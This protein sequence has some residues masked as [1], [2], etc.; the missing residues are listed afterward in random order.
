M[1]IFASMRIIS[2]NLLNNSINWKKATHL[3]TSHP[4]SN[5]GQRSV[6][7]NQNC[8]E[9]KWYLKVNDIYMLLVMH[10]I[11]Y[12]VTH[13][14]QNNFIAGGYQT[15]YLMQPYIKIILWVI[16]HWTVLSLFSDL[17]KIVSLLKLPD[18]EILA[19]PC[20][21]FLRQEPGTAE[22]AKDFACTRFKAEYPVFQ[23][24]IT[25][26]WTCLLVLDDAMVSICY[27]V[28]YINLETNFT[29]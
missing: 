12:P 3:V 19:F 15:N 17:I 10:Q 23:K 6:E 16:F 25:V 20:N 2:P 5:Y 11:L 4:A 21:Q 13:L 14:H 18:F 7:L 27:M 22:Q 24:V 1:K 9:F 8:K 28:G 29:Q 26:C